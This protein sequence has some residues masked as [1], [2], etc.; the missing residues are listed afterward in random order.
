MTTVQTSLLDALRRAVDELKA[1]GYADIEDRLRG[2]WRL[3]TTGQVF[4]ICEF[5]L[6]GDAIVRDGPVYREIPV[7]LLS[8]ALDAGLLQFLG[9]V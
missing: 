5:A 9:R 1:A 3:V 2:R 4:L 8:E 6:N 7:E